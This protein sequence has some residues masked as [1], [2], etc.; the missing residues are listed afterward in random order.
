MAERTEPEISEGLDAVKRQIFKLG[1]CV[2]VVERS[3]C[4]NE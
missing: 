1:F 2:D 4:E 3:T